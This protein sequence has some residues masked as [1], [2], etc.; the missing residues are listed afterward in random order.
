MIDSHST[1]CTAWGIFN[2]ICKPKHKPYGIGNEILE[3]IPFVTNTLEHHGSNIFTTGDIVEIIK[4]EQ[5]CNTKV[6]HPC[7]TQLLYQY[8]INCC[9]LY[10]ITVIHSTSNNKLTILNSGE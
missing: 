7:N 10:E 9:L 6:Q 3:T 2:K 8:A 5:T 1:D 4:N